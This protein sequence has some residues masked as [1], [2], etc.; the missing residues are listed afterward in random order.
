MTGEADLMEVR[1]PG[2]QNNKYD[3]LRRQGSAKN[4]AFFNVHI[5]IIWDLGAAVY[6][7]T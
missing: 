5:L 7:L 1:D 4:P 6:I 2:Q 3:I